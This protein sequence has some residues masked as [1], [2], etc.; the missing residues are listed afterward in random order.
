MSNKSLPSGTSAGMSLTDE[1][2]ARTHILAL[3]HRYASLAR[4]ESDYSMITELFEKDGIINFPDGRQLAPNQLKEIAGGN[5]PK[6]LRHHITTIDVQLVSLDEAHSQSYIIAGT[7]MRMP[8]HW[9][10]WDDVLK[11]QSDGRWLFQ[12]KTIMAEQIDPEGWLAETIN[13][14]ASANKNERE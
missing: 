4:E 14:A 6:L 8:D 9:G 1:A 10:R 2:I 13:L 3:I 5:P 11:R 7:H 12:R